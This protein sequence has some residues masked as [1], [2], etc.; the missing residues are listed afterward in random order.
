M[1]AEKV[2]SVAGDAY[3][4]DAD[5]EQR[6]EQAATGNAARSVEELRTKL[7]DAEA[8]IVVLQGQL[9]DEIQERQTAQEHHD[10]E[11]ARIHDLSANKTER[12]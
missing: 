10:R 8:T 3:V 6:Q 7:D 12:Y 5:I 9:N 1:I 11:M 4:V 2:R